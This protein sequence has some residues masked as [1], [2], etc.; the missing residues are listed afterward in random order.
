MPQAKFETATIISSE[1][2]TTLLPETK[3]GVRAGAIEQSEKTGFLRSVIDRLPMTV[4]WALVAQALISVTRILTTVTVGGRLAF[5]GSETQGSLG[6]QE[7]LGLYYG[8]FGVLTVLIALHEG[9]VTVPMT[10]FFPRQSKDN[11][12]KFSGHML[13]ASLCLIG[14]A[15]CCVAIWILWQYQFGGGMTLALTVIC[16]VIVLAPLQLLREFSRRWLLANLEVRPSALLEGLFSVTCLA[17][18]A[19]LFVLGKITA[20]NAFIAIAVMNVVALVVWWRIYRKSFEFSRGGV[21]K[22]LGENFRYGRWAAAEN[23]CS[24]ITIFFCVWF[25]NRQLGLI[26]GGVYSACFNVTMLANPFLLGVCSLLGARAAQE[27]TKGGWD[28]L[29]RTLLQYGTFI[30]VVLSGFSILLW[31]FGADLT[32]M[33]FGKKYQDWF[34]AN[35]GGV[36]EIT[37]TLGLAI[38]C[39]GVSFVLSTALLAIGRPQDNFICALASL[40]VLILINWTWGP[41]LK[42]A[43]ISYVSAMACNALLR[44]VCLSR[45]WMNREIL[46][47]DTASTA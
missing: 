37:A 36:N 12:S 16:F 23:C 17:T 21:K 35:S 41:G 18:L 1:L 31:V 7:Q 11:E 15:L 10:V 43:A 13:V 29:I 14:V 33:M 45:A 47:A 26:S 42:V 9:F 20:I 46:V 19:G 22:Q 34:V 39:L 28:S 40:F 27:F 24:T 38:P 6:S 3:I 4:F 2:Q 30:I 25:L 44:I 5:L 32:S 8:A